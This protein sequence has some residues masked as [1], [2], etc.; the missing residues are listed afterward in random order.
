VPQNQKLQVTL[1][2]RHS[3]EPRFAVR[4]RLEESLSVL[5]M[6]KAVQA[7]MVMLALYGSLRKVL[8][9]VFNDNHSSCSSSTR[10][11]SPRVAPSTWTTIAN[12][13]QVVIRSNMLVTPGRWVFFYSSGRFTFHRYPSIYSGGKLGARAMRGPFRRRK[14]NGFPRL[15]RNSTQQSMLLIRGSSSCDWSAR[16]CVDC[17]SVNDPA[18]RDS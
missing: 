16:T 10:A 4:I 7:F 11:C 1:P 5:R 6:A 9:G 14:P 15:T 2:L 3:I 13:T 17:S 12:I 8:R 18:K